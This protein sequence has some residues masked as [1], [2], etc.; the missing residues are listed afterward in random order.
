MGPT[1]DQD[2]IAEQ[3]DVDLLYKVWSHDSDLLSLR[4]WSMRFIMVAYR[5]A[6]YT[7][8][9]F[10]ASLRRRTAIGFS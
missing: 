10:S 7:T 2:V 3:V 6:N 5:G 9:A 1:P 4:L 8:V